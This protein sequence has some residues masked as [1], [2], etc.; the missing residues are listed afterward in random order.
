MI[1]KAQE[2]WNELHQGELEQEMMLPLIRLRVSLCR[3]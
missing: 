1:L 2:E 3:F